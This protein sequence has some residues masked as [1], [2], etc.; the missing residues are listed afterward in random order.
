MNGSCIPIECE[1]HN[2]NTLFPK[3]TRRRIATKVESVTMRGFGGGWN[4]VDDDVSM[5][6]TYLRNSKNFYRSSSGS[7]ILRF[8]NEYFTDTAVGANS[9]IVDMTYFNGRLVNVH[10]NG[11]ITTSTDAGTIA[12]IWSD[13]IA[14]LL[15][16]APSGW[17]AGVTLVTFVPSKNTLIIHNGTDKP[18]SVSSA[19]A[20]TYLQDLASGSNTNTPI[21]KYG[22]I[23]ANYHCV[24]GIAGS[25]T[26]IVISSAGAPGTFP[27]DPPPN[28]SISIDVA[29]YAPEGAAEIRGIAG[30]RSNLIVHL[31]TITLQVKL[32]VYDD[33][34][35]D[36]TPQF[37]DNFPTFGLLGSRCIAKVDNDLFFGGLVD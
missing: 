18:L 5:R 10:E 23:A 7:Q 25:P 26:E 16:G 13:A 12:L 32:G 3:S 34:S 6:P 9:P 29:A 37:P 2:V 11:Q 27:G 1:S 36:H 15:P 21:G 20:V 22:C 33:T 30:Y 31:Q 28:D 24:A 14:A 4:T 8:G 19:F 35:G 17:A